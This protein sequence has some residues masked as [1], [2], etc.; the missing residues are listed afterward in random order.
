M[1]SL[2]YT[3]TDLGLLQRAL[4]HPS[5][6]GKDN[7]QRLEFLGD[8][9]LQLC[10]SQAL[11]TRSKESE[12]KLSFRRQKLVN[13][14]SLSQIAREIGLGAHLILAPSF[15]QEGGAALDS[16]LA[17]ALEAVL[18]AV[19]LDGGLDA[20]RAL[21]DRLW[22]RHYQHAKA[23]LDPKGALQ[24]YA[25]AQGMGEPEYKDLAMQGPAHERSFTSGVFLTGRE[26]ARATERT[27]R[28][29]QQAAAQLALTFLQ[30][31][32]RE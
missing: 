8:A 12:G 22:S 16:V 27:K 13:E 17:D 15:A 1:A 11:L 14:Q 24:A 29:A 28:G 3:F 21:V 2:L 18:A 30:T 6:S 20:A 19:Y 26:L 5:A 9:V 7:N 31:E 23:S 4:T 32:E 25:A 10:V